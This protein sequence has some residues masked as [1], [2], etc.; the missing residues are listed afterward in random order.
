[1]L[2]SKHRLK[3]NQHNQCLRPYYCKVENILD[4]YIIIYCI[5][6]L[7]IKEI[8]DTY[9]IGTHNEDLIVVFYLTYWW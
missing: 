5:L 8:V 2:E 4:M 7:L 9:L 3:R 1:M 6:I